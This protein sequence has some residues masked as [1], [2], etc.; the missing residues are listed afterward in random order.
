M[1]G[2]MRPIS[3]LRDPRLTEPCEFAPYPDLITARNLALT[4]IEQ[5]KLTA[6]C[7]DRMGKLRI[8]Q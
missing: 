1:T 8:N 5:W 3:Q 7:S 4:L 6:E 2:C